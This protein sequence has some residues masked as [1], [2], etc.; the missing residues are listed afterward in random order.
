MFR[1]CEIC[2]LEHGSMAR[3]VPA[4]G[5]VRR[6]LIE[7]RVVSLCEIHVARYELSGTSTLREL[8]AIF[9]EQGGRRSLVTRRAPL[10]RRVFPARPEGRRHNAGRRSTDRA[11]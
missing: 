5:K 6:L 9:R 7:D 8:S 10:D 1:S 2:A 11:D 3:F 4:R